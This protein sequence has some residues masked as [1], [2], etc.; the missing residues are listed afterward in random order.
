MR[1]AQA[2]DV[3]RLVPALRPGGRGSHNLVSQ[4]GATLLEEVLGFRTTVVDGTYEFEACANG[5]YDLAFENWPQSESA[6]YQEWVLKKVRRLTVCSVKR[7]TV[8]IRP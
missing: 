3:C 7:W 1:Y 2:E 6:R 5:L 8:V 4:I